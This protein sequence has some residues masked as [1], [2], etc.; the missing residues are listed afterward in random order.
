MLI[1]KLIGKQE[2]PP[3]SSSAWHKTRE[4]MLLKFFVG[5]KKE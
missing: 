3:S 4:A 1:D 2:L 5:V